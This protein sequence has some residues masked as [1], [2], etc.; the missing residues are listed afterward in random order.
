ML[1]HPKQEKSMFLKISKLVLIIAIA[2][3]FCFL[4]RQASAITPAE[5]CQVHQDSKAPGTCEQCGTTCLKII[6]N[7]GDTIYKVCTDVQCTQTNT[8][9]ADCPECPCE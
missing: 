5:Y 8:C 9:S 6:G 4:A 3:G 1:G 2:F 7:L